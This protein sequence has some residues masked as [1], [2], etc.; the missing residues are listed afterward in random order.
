LR[1]ISATSAKLSWSCRDLLGAGEGLSA[2]RIRWCRSSLTPKVSLD[3]HRSLLDS[4]PSPYPTKVMPVTVPNP[5]GPLVCTSNGFGERLTT[6]LPS[7][8]ASSGA[9]PSSFSKN[10]RCSDVSSGALRR[11]LIDPRG[12]TGSEDADD[13]VVHRGAVDVVHAPSVVAP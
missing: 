11:E 7:S 5:A 10:L 2:V 3:R 12:E 8:G 4:P 6:P 13:L 9:G 1:R